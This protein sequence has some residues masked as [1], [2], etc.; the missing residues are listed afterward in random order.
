MWYKKDSLYRWIILILCFLMMFFCAGFCCGNSG[1]YLSAIT[2]A[3]GIKRSIYALSGTFGSISAAT[4]SLFFGALIYRF[5][6][7][8]MI[9][10][11]ILLQSIAFYIYSMAQ[12][13]FGFYIGG[14]LLG[15]GGCLLGTTMVSTLIKRWFSA[16]I[17]KFTGI[18][19]AANGFG[20]ALSAQIVSPMLN[21][22]TNLFG[23]RK[24]Y[25]MFIPI[26]LILGVIFLIF[27]QNQPAAG[28]CSPAAKSVIRKKNQAKKPTTYKADP[29]FYFVCIS[30]F[31]F[32][33]LIQS[34]YGI[35]AAY[36]KDIGLDAGVIA[37]VA[38]ILTLALAASKMLVG[39]LY[40]RLGLSP[41]LG[42]CQIAF[43]LAAVILICL[44]FA[45]SPL[46]AILFALIFPISMP[47]ETVCISLIA[48]DFFDRES[49][50][51][52]LGVISAAGSAGAAIGSP[53]INLCYDL[54]GSYI[55]IIILWG[56]LM[57]F[58]AAGYHKLSHQG[59]SISNN[60][61]VTK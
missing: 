57:L 14:T 27:I 10:A 38:S 23:F 44:Q 55:P 61:E 60:Q 45:L 34:I 48:S 46:L 25:G 13:V 9:C 17:G 7:R 11:G 26:L 21:D 52:R 1:L 36:M 58:I 59:K 40:D 24:V 28:L 53:L 39:F 29:V 50:E 32:L 22:P 42:I 43:V 12:N 18:V 4:T 8:K 6:P 35:Y 47:L 2:E 5:G 19:L 56:V 16:D 31:L 20:S 41:V 33:L 49:F 51:K 54:I 15:I 30:V 37:T 3:L